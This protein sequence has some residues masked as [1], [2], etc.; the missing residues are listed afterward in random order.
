MDKIHI[1]VLLEESIKALNVEP[2]GFYIDCTLGDGGHSNKILSQLSSQGLL[3]SIDR[4]QNAIDFV[5]GYY[6]IPPNWILV[7]SNF[8]QVKE[9][10]DSNKIEKQPN[11]ILMDL[12]LSSRQLEKSNDRGFSYQ[13]EAESLDMRMDTDLAVSALDLLKVLNEHELSKLFKLYGEEK[14]SKAIAKVIKENISEIK[15]VGDL[16]SLIYKVVPVASNNR[17]P[18]RRVFQALR[19]AVNDELNSLKDGLDSAFEVLSADGRLVVI[20]FH[21]LEDRIIK[22]F[23]NEK[24][25]KEE[26]KILS[27]KPITPSEDELQ[28]NPRSSS[29]KLR[30]LR[31]V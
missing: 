26:G 14:R 19:I 28:N 30:F 15:T 3:L 18:S 31:K 11:G 4:D 10:L 27:R 17:N 13:E 23:F 12:G 22:D 24:E 29:A 1:P 2:S 8:S 21:S 5:K 20:A 25:L 9:V 16:K 6:E 7:K